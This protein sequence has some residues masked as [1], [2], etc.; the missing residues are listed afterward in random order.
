MK[1]TKEMEKQNSSKITKR[2]EI[3]ERTNFY[4]N[5]IKSVKNN[6]SQRNLMDL[7]EILF[8]IIK[9]LP[10]NDLL[11]TS[12]VSKLWFKVSLTDDNLKYFF[13]N[14][15]PSY[16]FKFKNN[17]PEYHH[18]YCH[19]I[20]R[21]RP[22]STLE[23]RNE[24]FW[25]LVEKSKGIQ[26]EFERILIE[27][28]YLDYIEYIDEAYTSACCA[29]KDSIAHIKDN[30]NELYCYYSDDTGSD[31]MAEI[32]SKGKET[33]SNI[34]N[35]PELALQYECGVEGFQYVCRSYNY[36][37]NV[38]SLMVF[39]IP[40]LSQMNCTCVLESYAKFKSCTHKKEWKLKSAPA[41]PL[42][43]VGLFTT[44]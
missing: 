33:W 9:F 40:K 30:E 16:S 31:R 10:F 38:N 37:K 7:E 8:E 12:L 6:T 25:F 23:K 1:R 19:I 32:I 22:I 17:P 18:L 39:G 24:L 36:F 35:N 13:E 5:T 14:T 15:F 29:L 42:G 21:F 3:A 44:Q 28:S 27:E 11:K 34:C 41:P 4:D 43:F 20:E 2:N 26:E